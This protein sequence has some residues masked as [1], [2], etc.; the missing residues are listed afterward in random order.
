MSAELT[1]D[2]APTAGGCPSGL[3]PAVKGAAGDTAIIDPSPFVRRRDGAATLELAVFGAKCAGCISKIESA[4]KAFD[5]MERAR[6]NLSTGRL[7]LTWRD[8]AEWAPL[9]VTQTLHELGYRAAPF[10]PAAMESDHDAEGRRL[11]RALGVA[12]FAAANV[13]LLSVS[14]WSG[15]AE[16]GEGT[17]GLMHWASALI[18]VPAALYAGR[19]FFS[20]ALNA[21]KNRGA[22]M[23]VPISLAVILALSVSVYEFFAGGEHAYFDAAVMLLFFLLIG[24]YLDH[25]LR[26]RA[27]AAARDLLA[28]QKTTAQRMGEDG[29]IAAISARDV[30]I[31]DRLLLSP[32]DRA[33]VDGVIVEGASYADRSMVTGESAPEKLRV[34]DKIH[35]G[36][37]NVSDRLIMRAT[38]TVDN[39]LVADLARLIEAGEQSRSRYVRLADR[40]ARLYVPVVHSLALA[41]FLGWMLAGGGPRL[42]IMNAVAVLIITCPCALGLAAPAVQVV[43]TGRLFKRGVLVKSGDALERLAEANA[44][45]FD[46]TGTLTLGR[47]LLANRNAIDAADLRDAAALARISHHPLSRAIVEAAGPG[48]I[49]EDGVEFPGLGV[50]AMVDGEQLRLGSAEWIGAPVATDASLEAWFRRS[51][52]APVRFQFED[53]PHK[54]AGKVIDELAA[55]GL[56]SELLSGDREPAVAA[57][58]QTLGLADYRARVSPHDKA[59]RLAALSAAGVKA[60]MVGDGL[61]DAPSLAHAHVSLSP[62]TAADA[63]QAA[64]DFVYLGN[65]LAP[66][67]EAVDVSR[68]ARRRV[69]ENFAFAALYNACAIPLAVFGFVTPLIAALAMSGSSMVVTLNALRLTGG[70]SNGE[71]RLS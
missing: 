56:P 60:A 7:S 17:R 18:A 38:A 36:V 28:M 35:A 23:D 53:A 65:G 8:G 69:I 26:W 40:A 14:V 3:A 70:R 50:E 41:T 15:G 51:D 29:V 16:M 22:N 25:R 57:V 11:L 63:S 46:K 59:A 67:V 9:R 54:D 4:M 45:V 12:G 19:P 21:L 42:A 43:A 48:A 44:I 1:I 24:R 31:G 47:P 5:G 52:E 30:K 33:S 61:N 39:S 64:A 10:D 71:T 13:M 58:A 27:R 32:G 55:R 66:I 34:D 68:K 62:G 49:S 2:E 6:L 20:S 37:L